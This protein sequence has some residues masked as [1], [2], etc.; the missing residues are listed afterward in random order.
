V[1]RRARRESTRARQSRARESA[2]HSRERGGAGR[3]PGRPRAGRRPIRRARGERGSR[4]AYA[5][6]R[7]VRLRTRDALLLESKCRAGSAAIRESTSARRAGRTAPSASS[8][9][10]GQASVIVANYVRLSGCCKPSRSP[11]SLVLRVVG[12]QV[13]LDPLDRDRP[14]VALL[15]DVKIAVS[16]AR[17]VPADDAVKTPRSSHCVRR[18]R[19]PSV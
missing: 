17:G 10:R 12:H 15:Y 8:G 6:R 5:G 19:R 4:R 14:I 13:S 3:Q 11:Q 9:G 18:N 2:S 1:D 7:A 16:H